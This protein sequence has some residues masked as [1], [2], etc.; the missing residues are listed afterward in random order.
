VTK[1]II[2]DYWKDEINND[3]NDRHSDSTLASSRIL[4]HWQEIFAEQLELSHVST[5]DL[6]ECLLTSSKNS[7]LESLQALA[8]EKYHQNERATQVFHMLDEAGKGCV[9]GSDVLRAVQELGEL[10]S[11]SEDHI[12]PEQVEE[13]MQEFCTTDDDLLTKDD[14]IRIARIVNL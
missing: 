6:A 12:Q 14:I 4:S 13:M 10:S 8:I 9:V 1:K 5:D 11:A 2:R 7:V 3:D